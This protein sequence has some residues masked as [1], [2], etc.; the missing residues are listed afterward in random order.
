[1]TPTRN[2]KRILFSQTLSNTLLDPDQLPMKVSRTSSSSVY[3][4]PTNKVLPST[5]DEAFEEETT[6][7][8]NSKDDARVPEPEDETNTASNKKTSETKDDEGGTDT[9]PLSQTAS[10]DIMSI[11]SE[12]DNEDDDEDEVADLFSDASSV[13]LSKLPKGSMV[14]NSTD[15][16]AEKDEE[17]TPVKKKSSPKKG[18]SKIP[19]LKVSKATPT[20]SSRSSR[21]SAVSSP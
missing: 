1:M 15:S 9:E 19:Q 2:R 10:I 18:K 13:N 7:I 4:S 8:E 14:D 6:L 17:R 11:T 3:R 12:P 16:D 5:D 20:R 21:S